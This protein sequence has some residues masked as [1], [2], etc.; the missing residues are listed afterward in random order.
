VDEIQFADGFD[1]PDRL[2]FGLGAG[3]LLTVVAGGLIAY[4]ITRSP[5]PGQVAIPIA[6]ALAV[7]AAALGWLRITGRPALDW[8][9]FTYRYATHPRTGTLLVA[10]D[11][12]LPVRHE[13][14]SASAPLTVSL[15]S[16][17]VP[18]AGIIPLRPLGGH[19]SRKR[20]LAVNDRAS[21]PLTALRI[22][23][24]HRIT[25][26]SLKGGTG[27]TTLAVEL[28]CALAS[29][30]RDRSATTTP[31]RVALLDLDVRCASVAVRLGL[32]SAG[33][34]E[35][36]LA[37]PDD[38][39]V[40]D[41][42]AVHPSGAHVL[43]GLPGLA[44]PDWPITA[45]LLR[46]LL[47]DLDIEGFDFVVMDVSPELCAVTRAA[48]N[49]SDDVFVV[50]VPTASGVQDAYRTTEQLRHVGLRHQ[51]RYVVNRAR[52]DVDVSVTIADLAGQL[53]AEI[54]DDPAL[55]DAENSHRVVVQ[56]GDSDAARALHRLARRIR[57]EL[58][59]VC[60]T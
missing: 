23:G 41:F 55:A 31:P 4:A 7:V 34:M 2:A 21:S 44:N 11:D 27:R 22:G 60:A 49:S 12:A 19:V 42:M 20:A 17:P 38:R 40:S 37:P 36:A 51:L 1:A 50:V 30:S 57:S 29:G 24:A 26:F 45:P 35:F 59:F 13:P 16:M 9:V 48:L 32:S 58:A 15:R 52:G 25:F 33:L 46:E 54:P 3:Q 53:I 14:G 56:R 18:N 28:A 8:A 6:L 47:R 39:R 43:V 5:L 10:V